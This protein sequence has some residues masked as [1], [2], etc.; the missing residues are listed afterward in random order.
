[1][2]DEFETRLVGD[3]MVRGQLV[4][5]SGRSSN[6]SRKRFCNPGS[7]LD[8]IAAMCEDVTREAD[9]NSLFII[10]LGTN[11]AK[12]TRSTE[13]LEK[14]HRMIREYKRRTDSNIIIISGILPRVG[15]EQ[16]LQQG[17]QHQ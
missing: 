6:S 8:D 9:H 12:T 13:V 3:S 2:E 10:H 7:R 15:D 11:D 5:F 4:E 17:V 16:F 1:M 14:Y